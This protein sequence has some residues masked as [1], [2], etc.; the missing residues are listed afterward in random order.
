MS[1]EREVI[2]K[3]TVKQELLGEL[4]HDM[5]LCIF[6]TVF[7]GLMLLGIFL[8]AIESPRNGVEYIINA[9]CILFAVFAVA[10]IFIAWYCT[11]S[12]LCIIKKDKFKIVVDTLTNVSE[13]EYC[14]SD[15]LETMHRRMFLRWHVHIEDAFY[16]SQYGRV[17]VSKK[18]S[19]YSMRGD[20]FYLVIIPRKNDKVVKM[21][22]SRIYRYEK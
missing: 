7:W 9:V 12:N 16:F 21:Y 3:E 11:I 20:V 13:D 4:K 19:A 6:D 5:I 8:I 17:S 2:T 22:N 1:D 14:Q 15:F 18:V 10:F